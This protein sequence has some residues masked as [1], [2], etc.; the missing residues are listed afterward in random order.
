MTS[1]ELKTMIRSAYRVEPS[2]DKRAFVKQFEK[3]ELNM[4][5]ILKQQ[6]G[7]VGIVNSGVGVLVL[8]IFWQILVQCQ[9]D[10]ILVFARISAIIPIIAVVAITGIG[11]SEKYGMDELEKATRFSLRTVMAGRLIVIGLIDAIVLIALMVA[12]GQLTDIGALQALLVITIPYLITACGCLFIT[13]KLHARNDLAVCVGYAG[14]VCLMCAT[15]GEETPW[16]YL[17]MG[18][19]ASYMLCAGLC[20][21]YGIEINKLLKGENNIWNLC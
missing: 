16:R 12:F 10:D 5:D 3:R 15:T 13:R 19:A 21:M 9:T 17:F 6:L 2:S 7:N 14:V 20:L 18:G 1:R 4:W 8:F 11:R